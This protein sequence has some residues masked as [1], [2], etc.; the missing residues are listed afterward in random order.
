[1]IVDLLLGLGLGAIAAGLAYGWRPAG[2]RFGSQSGAVGILLVCL[3]TF[4]AGGWPWGVL[5]VA[6][7]L[8]TI[9]WS[10][11][12][13]NPKRPLADRY[14]SGATRGIDQVLARTGWA[15]VLAVLSAYAPKS[16]ALYAAF[17]GA[18]AAATAD[19]WA[20]EIGALSAFLP[21]TADPQWGER[22]AF[23][24]HYTKVC[25]NDG[26]SIETLLAQVDEEYGEFAPILNITAPA[27]SLVDC[28]TAAEPV[29]S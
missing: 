23:K 2:V 10:H 25:P 29:A 17:V 5:P 11:Y 14:D 3:V 27:I 26:P 9:F 4:L 1:M 19:A 20:T 24:Q 21:A 15:T 13:S 16:A 18:W 7:F 12:R 28:F 8:S 6:F 22:D